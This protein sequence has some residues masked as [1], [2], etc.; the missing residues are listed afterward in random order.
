MAQH[1][2]TRGIQSVLGRAYGKLTTSS[3]TVDAFGAIALPWNTF[4]ALRVKATDVTEL[5]VGGNL[6]EQS[7]TIYFNWITKN[8]GIF[9]ADLDTNSAPT[10]N[11]A[12]AYASLTELV[13][14]TSVEDENNSPSDFVLY[15]NYP[16]PFNPA[17]V[18]KYNIPYQANVSLRVYDMLGNE[19]TTLVNES[20][21]AGDYEAVFNADNLS[22]GIYFYKLIAGDVV[23]TKKM[24]LIR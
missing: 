23:Q 2:E 19:I 13:N 4:D 21:S 24:V 18:I 3:Q 7:T 8:G 9:E 16:N 10:G 17:T 11:V 12:L 22:S 6:F 15:Q 1:L 5:Y 14:T 20:K